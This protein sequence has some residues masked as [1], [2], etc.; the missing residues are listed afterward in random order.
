[1]RTAHTPRFLA[2]LAITCALALACTKHEATSDTPPATAPDPCSLISTDDL[3]RITGAPLR[4]GESG[5]DEK[6]VHR[7]VWQEGG[8][9]GAGSI[10]VAIHVTN[11][12]PLLGQLRNVPMNEP[13]AGIGD[14]AFWSNALNQLTVHAG[15]RVIVISFNSSGGAADHKAAAIEIAKIILNGL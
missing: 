7:C 15:Q 11:L 5:G 2:T 12:E 4:E 10:T 13:V 6:S 1:M 14:E 9:A 8:E 3:K